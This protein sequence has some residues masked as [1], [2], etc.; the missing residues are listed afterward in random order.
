LK[1]RERERGRKDV[2]LMGMYNIN[3]KLNINKF[4]TSNSL[5]VKLKS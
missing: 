2:E 1:E 3:N 5:N 4:S